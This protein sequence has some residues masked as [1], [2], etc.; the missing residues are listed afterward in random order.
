MS[1]VGAKRSKSSLFRLPLLCGN[2]G[3]FEH[4]TMFGCLGNISATQCQPDGVEL[5]RIAGRKV[6]GPSGIVF[7]QVDLDFGSIFAFMNELF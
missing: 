7:D 2:G 5:A 1:S 6:R 4:S 3:Q